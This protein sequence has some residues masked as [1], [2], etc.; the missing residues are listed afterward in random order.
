MKKDIFLGGA[1]GSTTWRKEIAIPLLNDAGVSYFNP[2]LGAGEWT[3]ANEAAELSAKAEATALLFVVTDET[4][5]V[6]T[7]AEIAYYIGKGR[8]LSL[9]VNDIGADK[10]FDGI[11]LSAAERDDLNRGRIFV[12]TMAKNDGV[13]VFE[14]VAGA[15]GH[16]IGIVNSDCNFSITPGEPATN[17]SSDPPVIFPVERL[18]SGFPAPQG[19][20]GKLV[21]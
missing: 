21:H 11:K 7:L 13:P 5:G 9:V 18:R 20:Q 6:A 16:A 2:Q 8:P 4:R 14:D 3:T 17:F 15:V 19:P 12:R 1:S 10:E